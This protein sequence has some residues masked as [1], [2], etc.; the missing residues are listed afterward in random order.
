MFTLKFENFLE[1]SL[2]TLTCV[3]GVRKICY[4]F[5]LMATPHDSHCINILVKN[6]MNV[7]K[8]TLNH[9]L[10]HRPLCVTDPFTLVNKE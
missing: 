10:Y 8:T 9:F 3:A 2:C 4:Y 1:L 6:C 5:Y 7:F